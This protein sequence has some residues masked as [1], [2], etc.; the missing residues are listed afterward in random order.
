MCSIRKICSLLSCFI[1][2]CLAFLSCFA[3]LLFSHAVKLTSFLILWSLPLSSSLRTCYFLNQLDL[4]S[5]KLSSVMSFLLHA[6]FHTTCLSS[7]SSWC[8][9]SLI[10]RLPP[11][12]SAQP[13]AVSTLPGVISYP[14]PLFMSPLHWDHASESNCQTKLFQIQLLYFSFDLTL[15]KYYVILCWLYFQIEKHKVAGG[16]NN[17]GVVMYRVIKTVKYKIG[18]HLSEITDV[19]KNM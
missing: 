7:T 14:L 15:L 6:D 18:I 16:V 9:R 13:P 5:L 12:N 11:P 17:P 10:R 3:L 2:W 8:P 1:L 4:C 19:S